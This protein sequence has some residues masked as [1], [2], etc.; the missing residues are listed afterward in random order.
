MMR[1]PDD[2]E[3]YLIQMEVQH[4]MLGD[5]LW[6]VKGQGPDLVV[7][8]AG[9]VVVFR[10]RVLDLTKVPRGRREGLYHTLLELNAGG[11]L[12]GAYGLEGDSVVATAALQ[13]ENLDFNEFQAAID[14]L[15][16]AVSNHYATLSKLAA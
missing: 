1:G 6:V 13:L 16:M 10:M 9:P 4:D 12:H 14:D 15:G 5:G 2:I 8:I 7:S 3:S 11:M